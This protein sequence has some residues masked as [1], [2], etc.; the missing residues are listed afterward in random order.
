MGEFVVPLKHKE[1]NKKILCP[2]LLLKNLQ[3]FEFF[4]NLYEV[5]VN[6]NCVLSDLVRNWSQV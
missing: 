1:R 3:V 4:L 5:S 2:F 6:L